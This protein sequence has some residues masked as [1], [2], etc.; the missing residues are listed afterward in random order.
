MNIPSNRLGS[1]LLFHF[2]YTTLSTS[3]LKARK[4]KLVMVISLATMT[5]ER[6]EPTW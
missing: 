4:D 5:A 6:S 1:Q 2:D 3:A